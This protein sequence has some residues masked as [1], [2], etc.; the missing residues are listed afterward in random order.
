M[1][2]LNWY[3]LEDTKSRRVETQ[4][5]VTKFKFLPGENATSV[6][7]A[8]VEGVGTLRLVLMLEDFSDPLELTVSFVWLMTLWVEPSITATVPEV[9]P[10]QTTGLHTHTE[11]THISFFNP[12][13]ILG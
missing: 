9:F 4:L 11:F 12:F 3:V 1:Y 8:L 10:T 6:M 2:L 5:Y 7:T 13:L